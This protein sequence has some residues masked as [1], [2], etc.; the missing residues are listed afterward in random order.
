MVRF[1]DMTK[2]YFYMVFVLLLSACRVVNNDPKYREHQTYA[3]FLDF[4]RERTDSIISDIDKTTYIRQK[5]AELIDVGVGEND[6]ANINPHWTQAKGEEF[7]DIFFANKATVKCGGTAFFLQNIYKDLGYESY[8]YDM[9]CSSLYTHQVT[10]VRLA[11]DK[12]LYV[13]DAFYNIS[14]YDK[15]DEHY[16]SFDE[17]LALL[18][19]SK[20]SLIVIQWDKYQYQPDFDTTGLYAAI[21]KIGWGDK[22]E[23]LLKQDI[24]SLSREEFVKKA[25]S[26]DNRHN[27]C[28]RTYNFPES[29]LY[30]FLLPL[31]HNDSTINS[32]VKATIYSPENNEL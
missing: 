20:D 15:Y 30:F 19:K 6:F 23:T 21:E 27:E 5:T 14:Y 2:F 29:P 16:L 1:M 13:Q 31:S 10:L 12:K 9:G 17:I 18:N 22:Y 11:S 7:Y 32:F 3:E 25:Q 4:L 24:S 8:T 26:T 28:L